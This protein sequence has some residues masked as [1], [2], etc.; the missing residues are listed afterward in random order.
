MG[1]VSPF[2]WGYNPRLC[3]LQ[4]VWIRIGVSF[5][6]RLGVQVPAV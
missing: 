6:I 5:S 3:S 1:G 2:V 4:I